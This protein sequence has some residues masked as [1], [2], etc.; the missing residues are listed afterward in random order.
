MKGKIVKEYY[1][2]FNFFNNFL[3]RSGQIQNALKHLKQC[4]KYTFSTVDKAIVYNN[5]TRLYLIVNDC[6][7]S[8]KYNKICL[9]HILTESNLILK[10]RFSKSDNNFAIETKNKAELLSFLFYNNGYL[11]EK[12]KYEEESYY[13]YQKGMQFSTSTLGDLNMLS[14][15]FRPKL[16]NSRIPKGIPKNDYAIK[17][18]DSKYDS[19]SSL[20]DFNT[21]GKM[22]FQ[23]KINK[24][25]NNFGIVLLKFFLKIL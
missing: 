8:L 3:C 7:S 25:E 13:I 4:L 18:I 2:Y 6:S 22:K 5:I 20:I 10:D 12:L 15:K 17:T 24:N 16:V 11:M 9:E 1:L 14:N 21:I 23:K 19:D